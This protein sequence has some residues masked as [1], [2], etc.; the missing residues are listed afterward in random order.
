[1]ALSSGRYWTGDLSIKPEAWGPAEDVQAAVRENADSIYGIDPESIA[2]FVP[3]WNTQ[4]QIDYSMNNIQATIDGA[5][6]EK[7]QFV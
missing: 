3:F 2:L 6:V 4:G 5:K 1:M 7:N